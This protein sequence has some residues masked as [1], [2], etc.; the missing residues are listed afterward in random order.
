[1]G[2]AVYAARNLVKGPFAVINA[3]DFYG[4]DGFRKLSAALDSGN[5]QEFC[6]CGFYLENT[7]SENG[8]VSR[9]ICQLNADHTLRTVVEHTKIERKNGQ[10][11]STLEDGGSVVF[12]GREIVSMNMWGFQSSLFDALE[13]QFTDFL[14]AHGTEL[15]SEFYIPFVA[16][17]LVKQGK[18]TVKVLTSDDS[19]F[20][21]T[22]QEDK[23]VV[24]SGLEALVKAGRYP[25]KLFQV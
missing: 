14:K 25:E 13:T 7:L 21:V 2:Q 11:V 17:T 10:I 24:K 23:P 16:D 6:M 19:W 15:K 1:T 4:A 5:P 18:A 12:T 20:G 9:G 8:S 3:D 22:Y